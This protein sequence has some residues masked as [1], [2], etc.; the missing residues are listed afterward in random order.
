MAASSQPLP[1]DVHLRYGS[2]TMF[3]HADTHSEQLKLLAADDRFNIVGAEGEFYR[4][5]LADDTVG[6]VFAHNVAGTDLP[7][8]QVEQHLKD[9][10]AAAARPADGWRG[11]LNRLRGKA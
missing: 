2:A 1:N 3:A 4:V 11:A 5:V 8:T 9:E 6:F 10:R 7:L